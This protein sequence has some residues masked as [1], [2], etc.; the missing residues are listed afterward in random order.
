[1]TSSTSNISEELKARLIDMAWL[2]NDFVSDL[3]TPVDV[4]FYLRP[5]M[6]K[7]KQNFMSVS[8]LCISSLIIS[9]CKIREIIDHYGLEIREFPE[10]LRNSLYDIKSKIEK[11]DMYA[12]RSRY[13]AHSFSKEKGANQK[14]L[15]FD[16]NVKSLMKIIDF[17]LEPVTK[18]VFAF[19]D[20]VHKKDDQGSVVYIVYDTVRH[21]E[22]VVGD[23]RTRS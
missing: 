17:G 19:C 1:M 16:Q 10:S 22:S 11:S 15:T 23:L 3:K 18:N 14:P 9:L 12:Y 8:R 13:V 7:S 6:D 20:W 2:L 21:I 4:I 5:E